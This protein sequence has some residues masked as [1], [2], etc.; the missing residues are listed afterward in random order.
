M[1]RSDSHAR[2]ASRRRLLQAGAVGLVGATAGCLG[3]DG[4]DDTGDDTDDTGD[5]T[6]APGDD[7]ADDT[8]ADDG[9][10]DELSQWE[11]REGGT[12]FFAQDAAPIDFDPID[13]TDGTSTA[14]KSQVFSF[15]YEYAQNSTEVVAEG[16]ATQLPELER[17]GT[18]WIV[19]ITD[20]A[21]FHNGDPVT[22]E[23]VRYS[24]QAPIDEE[25]NLA[26]SFE[27]FENIETIDEHTVQFDLSHPYEGQ[28][29]NMTMRIVPK[30]VRENDVEAFGDEVVI[31]SGPFE[32]VDWEEGQEVVMRRWD[33]YWGDELPHI[34]EMVWVPVEEATTRVTELQTDSVDII[35]DVIPDLRPQVEGMDDAH[36]MEQETLHY[37]FGAFVFAGETAKRDVRRG[38]SHCVDLN[39]AVEAQMGDT[40][41]RVYSPVDPLA[42][43]WDFP[44][45]RWQ[46]MD[47]ERDVDRARELFEQAGVPDDWEFIIITPPDDLRADL[48]LS[49]ANGVTEAGYNGRVRQ[50]DWGAFME[51]YLTEDPDQLNM[52][53]VTLTPDPDPHQYLWLLTHETGALNGTGWEHDEYMEILETAWQ[54]TDHDE[55]RELYIDAV[56]ILLEERIHLT[57][58]NQNATYGVKDYVKDT[59][60]Q[61]TAV[62]YPDIFSHRRN[63]WL[64]I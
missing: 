12:L 58:A 13:E 15:L 35:Q 11:E 23:D 19:P 42:E 7:S 8:G 49:I 32:F 16:L 36:L 25:R 46:G 17:D 43:A 24:F 4:A 38:V 50:L 44:V 29:H 60:L 53:L 48:A 57:I 33:D 39:S 34:E 21:Y 30:E 1:H 47:E 20:E 14:I 2:L 64:D 5:D 62:N 45:D 52:Y 3:D 56:D 6:A 18:R 54:S 27:I 51:T 31:G 26:S 59:G 63:A 40:G 41:N 37:M 55:R 9:A 61:P 10:E 22:A 28:I